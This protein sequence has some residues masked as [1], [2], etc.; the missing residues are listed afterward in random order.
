MKKNMGLTDRIIRFG[1][2]VLLIALNIKGMITG[3]IATVAIIVVVIFL[4]TSIVGICPLYS[5]LGIKSNRTPAG[6]NHRRA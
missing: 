1:I 5:L 3:V 4:I 2:A 6:N